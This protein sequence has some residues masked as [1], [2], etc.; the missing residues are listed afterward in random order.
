MPLG[1]TDLYNNVPN[2][3]TRTVIDANIATKSLP[4]INR[5][6]GLREN[7][8][9]REA[10]GIRGIMEEESAA[11]RQ[12][13]IVWFG[14]KSVKKVR[15]VSSGDGVVED[16]FA[17]KEIGGIEAERGFNVEGRPA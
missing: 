9:A 15:E 7:E 13:W 17:G 5:P 8:E 12:I 10:H 4:K 6:E 11:V 1:G 3:K 14:G 2:F 16:V